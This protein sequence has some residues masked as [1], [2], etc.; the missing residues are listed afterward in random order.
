MA[1]LDAQAQLIFLITI[2]KHVT[3]SKS[4]SS[5]FTSNSK[6]QIECDDGRQ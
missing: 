2:R 6:E 3:P 1:T 4:F 5:K